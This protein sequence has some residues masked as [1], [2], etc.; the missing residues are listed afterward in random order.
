MRLP[1]R[2]Q[3]GVSLTSCWSWDEIAW[4]RKGA[5][6]LA[7]GHGMKCDECL[8]EKRGECYSHAVGYE[9]R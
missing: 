7:V 6:S 3:G 4:Q 1:G 8:A 5:V 2:K 9:M